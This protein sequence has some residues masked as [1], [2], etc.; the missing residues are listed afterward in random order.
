MKDVHAGLGL[1]NM[2]DLVLKQIYGIYKT[3]TVTKEQI[4]KNKMTERKI[5]KTFNNLT[6]DKLNT[7]NNKNVYVRN[8]VM[9]TTMK[10]SRDKKKKEKKIPSKKKL[11]IPEF[12]LDSGIF[13]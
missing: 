11:M 5:F 2:S 13:L 7:K 12:F 6:K 9:T 1:E 8:D 4:R 10:P 3:K